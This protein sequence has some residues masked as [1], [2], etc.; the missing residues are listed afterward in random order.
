MQFCDLATKAGLY[1]KTKQASCG[2]SAIS[3]LFVN[4]MKDHAPL[5]LT[6]TVLLNIK[7][8]FSLK[9]KHPLKIADFGIFPLILP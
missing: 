9:V 1:S 5:P 4:H 2:L 3:E 6:P 8:K 7:F